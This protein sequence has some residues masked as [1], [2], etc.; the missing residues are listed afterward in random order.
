MEI[1]VLYLKISRYQL[2]I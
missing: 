1:T 2:S